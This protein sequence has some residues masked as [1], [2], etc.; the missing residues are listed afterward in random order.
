MFHSKTTSSGVRLVGSLRASL[1]KKIPI[2]STDQPETSPQEPIQ[3]RNVCGPH[4]ELKTKFEVKT[5]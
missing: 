4:I 3:S 5:H 2:G 1:S